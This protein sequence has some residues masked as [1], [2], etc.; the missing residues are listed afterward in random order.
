MALAI[1]DISG[2][3]HIGVYCHSTESHLFFPANQDDKIALRMA[4]TLEVEKVGTLVGGTT[5]LGVFICA[6]TRGMVVDRIIGDEERKRLEEVIPV[7]VVDEK[8]NALGNNVL[9]NDRRAMVHPSL[10]SDTVK[11]IEETLC[12]E[13]QPGTIAG[14]GTVGANAVV[15]DRGLLCHPKVTDQ[16]KSQLEEFFGVEP[17][18]GT[19]NYGVPLVGACMVAN[20]K[21][22]V[23]GNKTSGIELGRIEDA[24]FY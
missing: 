14:S 3:P 24:L 23:A 17:M 15:T 5:L 4:Q 1:E 7:V 16:E 21:G 19:A 18:I 20:G 10:S 22:A 13:T 8:F 9:A 2:N 12:V 11:A 6:N